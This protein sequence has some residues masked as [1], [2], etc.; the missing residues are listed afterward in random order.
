MIPYKGRFTFKQC[1]KNKPTRWGIK[2]FVLSDTTNDYVYRLQIYTGKNLESAVDVGLCSRVLLDLMT[3]LY[4]HHLYTDNYYTSP[5]AYLK[6]YD[7][8]INCCGTVRTN[9][10]GF[11]K[12]LVKPKRDKTDRGYYDYLSNGPLLAAAWFDRR[13]VS[14][15]HV[16][17]SQGDMVRR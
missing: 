17:A 15:L 5:E 7:Q 11:P 13:Y 16:G 14:T 4:K 12:E 3:G 8:G 10:R 6:L 1:M 9:R 2:I